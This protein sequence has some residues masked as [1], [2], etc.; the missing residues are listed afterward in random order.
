M[1]LTVKQV[2]NNINWLLK[3]G[4]TPVR[5]LTQKNLLKT[6][7]N[8]K[9]MRELW[10][11]VESCDEINGI[12]NKQE[13]NGSWCAGG[14]WAL[15][16]SYKPKDGT[17][18]YNPK[19]VSTVWVL[20]ILGEIGFTVK[21]KR[22]KKSCD[23][24]LSHGYFRDKIFQESAVPSYDTD[25]S[26][27]RFSQ[28]LIALSAV[29]C[30]NDIRLEKGYNY[31]LKKQRDDGGWVLQ[32]HLEERNW[33]RSCP[34]STYHAATALFYKKNKDKDSIAALIRALKFLIQHLSKKDTMDICRFFYHGH[35]T[36]KE[37]LMISE[38]Y[39]AG[40]SESAVQT[41]IKWIMSMYDEAGYF[42]YNGKP[43]SQ[44]TQKADGIDKRVAKYRL[45]HL[46]ENDWLTLYMTMICINML[47]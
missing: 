42:K 33:N 39:K 7:E 41:I 40:M 36:I 19:Y 16:P 9:E 30:Y 28:Y 13:M 6:P 17:D 38:Y 43:I 37:L 25:I 4:S 47:M 2:E 18:P 20:P 5:Y 24:V 22:I 31:L 15:K 21:D 3:N 11:E 14:S 27:C 34:W 10:L 32:K 29:D 1:I 45:Y 23:Y 12:F 26:P 46:I 44:Y 8:S 35:S